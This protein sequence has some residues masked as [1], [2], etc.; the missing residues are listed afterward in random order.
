MNRQD[1]DRV[2]RL[3]TQAADNRPEVATIRVTLDHVVKVLRPEMPDAQLCDIETLAEDVL[4]HVADTGRPA[5][6]KHP[7]IHNGR[8]MLV[9]VDIFRE[10]GFQG[11]SALERD[12]LAAVAGYALARCWQDVPEAVRVRILAQTGPAALEVVSALQRQRSGLADA[13][14]GLL[15]GKD[16]R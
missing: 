1:L 4:H 8:R 10:P 16:I 11:A 14:E 2:A 15:T 12:H 9:F 3:A 7:V 5:S 13:V 6:K